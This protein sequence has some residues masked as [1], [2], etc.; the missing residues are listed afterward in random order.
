MEMFLEDFAR[1]LSTNSL[2]ILVAIATI[3]G[4]LSFLNQH[5][6]DR[7][8]EIVRE[9]KALPNKDDKVRIRTIHQQNELFIFRYR[10]TALSLVLMVFAFASLVIAAVTASK[11]DQYPLSKW[12]AILTTSMGLI[13]AVSGLILLVREF[14]VG[15]ITLEENAQELREANK[16]L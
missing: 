11:M 7:S 13:F 15:H 5:L 6:S 10:R 8:R 3:L 14:V 16:R 9:F 1:T 4:L 12:I 2:P